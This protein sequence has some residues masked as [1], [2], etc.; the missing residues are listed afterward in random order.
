MPKVSTRGVKKVKKIQGWLV[1]ARSTPYTPIDWFYA[2]SCF[3]KEKE[4]KYWAE[5]RVHPSNKPEIVECEIT[6]SLPSKAKK[7]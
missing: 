2:Y 6:Y 7:K 1:L 3:S 5:T 4:A